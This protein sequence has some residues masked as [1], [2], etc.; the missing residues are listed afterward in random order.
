M[1]QIDILL[2]PNDEQLKLKLNILLLF[3]VLILLKNNG[4]SKDFNEISFIFG[5]GLFIKIFVL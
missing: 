2:K 3:E 4:I 5:I 1:Q